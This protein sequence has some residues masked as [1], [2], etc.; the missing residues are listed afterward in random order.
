[1]SKEDN[2]PSIQFKRKK[3]KSN[4][5]III[6]F[7]RIFLICIILVIILYSSFINIKY[8]QN[9]IDMNNKIQNS[10]IILEYSSLIDKVKNSIV[11][12]S[13][14]EENLSKGEFVEGNTTGIIIESDGKILTNYSV[15]SDV[16][17]IYVELPLIGSEPIKADVIVAN[18]DIDIAIIKVYHDEELTPIKIAPRSDLIE[19]KRVALISN[20]TGSEYIDSVIPGVIT[21]TNRK[22]NI[23]DKSYDLVEVNTPINIMNTGGVISNAN[24]E[25]ICI[26]SKK[27]T[28]DMNIS[29][30][31]YALDLSSIEKVLNNTNEIKSILGILEGGFIEN[32]ENGDNF[33]GLY[34]ARINLNNSSYESELK[35]TDIIFEID[36]KKINNTN[37]VLKMLK[38]KKAGDNITCKVMRG[39][40]EEEINIRLYNVNK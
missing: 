9:I 39:G 21:S 2:F 4:V 38:N 5:K 7:L 28:D 17:N 25:L 20:S 33:M 40:K 1:M 16:N 37:E 23:N 18:K 11:T 34:V 31:Y 30:L 12:I 14:S 32:K 22:L 10:N 26:A 24:G 27:A 3:V 8:K 13:R 29:G 19:G 6:K 15:I 35:P 36:G